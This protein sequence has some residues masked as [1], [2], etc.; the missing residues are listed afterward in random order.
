MTIKVGISGDDFLKADAL[1]SVDPVLSEDRV[2]I[3]DSY[4]S[5]RWGPLG[6][7][8]NAEWK[9]T[10]HVLSHPSGDR[11]GVVKNSAFGDEELKSVAIRYEDYSIV[12][13]DFETVDMYDYDTLVAFDALPELRVVDTCRDAVTRTSAILVVMPE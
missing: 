6:I 8:M 13:V 7:D 9:T 4:G 3:I 12:N 5:Q 10:Y 11:L 2:L 1:A